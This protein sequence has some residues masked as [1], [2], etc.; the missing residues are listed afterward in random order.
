[1]P[2]ND[3]K[4]RLN[5]QQRLDIISKL[6][7]PNP[8]S[9]HSIARE[10]NVDKKAVRRIWENRANIEQRSSTMSAAQRATT[11]RASTGQFSEIEAR[12]YSWIEAMRRANLTV[13][14]TLAIVKAKQIAAELSIS[15]DDF[16]ASWQWLRRFRA[17]HGLQ[18]ILLHGKGGEVDKNDPALLEQLENLYNIIKE[19]D[20]E[21]VYNMDEPGLFY[22]QLPWFSL[23]MPNEDVSTVRGTKKVKDH[24]SLVV[25]ANATGSHKV[26]CT[27]IGKAKTPACI[28]QRHWPVPYYAQKKAWMDKEICWKWF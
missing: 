7:K 18:E 23:L 20:A 1:M 2:S 12:L 25:C 24:V 16:K 4:K 9:K 21:H 28:K 27:L 13:S 6:S 3:D 19:Y 8:P 14:P 5:E 26:S 11:F 17:R 22:R 15:E 10:Y